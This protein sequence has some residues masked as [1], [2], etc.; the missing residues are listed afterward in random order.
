MTRPRLRR[1]IATAA[2]AAVLAA[3][4]GGA[5]DLVG[6]DDETTST[7]VPTE[8]TT[9]GS[10][11]SPTDQTT[12]ESPDDLPEGIGEGPDGEGLDRFYDQQVTWEGCGSADEC[13]EIWVPL[14][15]ADP[16]GE[17]VT[18]RAARNLAGDESSR[19]GS[20]LINP[21]G[22]GGSGIDYLG[23]AAFDST[24]TDVYDVVGFDPRGVASSTPLDC[25]SDAELD[26]YVSSDPTPDDPGE[27]D[28]FQA[29][30]ADFTEG[31]QTHSGELLGHVSTVEAARDI[32]II[33]A[34][35]GDEELNFF[36]ASYGTYLG[37]TYAALFPENVGRLVLD[38]AIDPLADPRQAA[39]D[40]AA[41]FE[42]ALTAYLEYC[43]AQGDCPLGDT[44]EDSRERLIQL[45][46][47][48]DENPL[49][50]S[51]GRE[52]TEGLAF[53]GVIVP[54]YS[55]D[56]W[57]Y[58]TDALRA[59]LDG[60]GDDLLFLA[61]LYAERQPDGTYANNGLEAQPAVNCLDHPDDAS[62]EEIQA[63][64]GDF[65]E[66]SPTFGV[67]AM[68][69]PYACSNWPVEAAEPHPDYSAAGAAPIVV[70]GTTRDPATPYEGAVK[71]AETLESG[72][73]LSRDGD[74]HTAYGMG[75]SCIDDAINT[76]LVEGTPP[77]DGTEC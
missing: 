52:V 2:A 22:P 13:A 62:I 58:E 19:I 29:D 16:D 35:V 55:R 34:V 17:A 28:E 61:D 43:V 1:L 39:I 76:Y 31:C 3:G 4:C 57:S 72:V 10:T 41:G 49:P 77:E 73:L 26:E 21:G 64:G 30:W 45:F 56:S 20:L 67:A 40:Q 74:G 71:L 59:A 6:D 47:E 65:I 24:V 36:G 69:W 70:V 14:D 25:L 54:L 23:Y 32:D 46:E 5:E 44:V 33:R 51:S 68:W 11:P 8:Q 75:N 38:G 66:A 15:Y 53:L 9:S 37:A 42:V 63:G 48:I 12:E 60:S 50:T 27:L 18:V 7:S